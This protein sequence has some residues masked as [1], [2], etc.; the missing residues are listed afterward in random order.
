MITKQEAI[1]LS[2]IK[3]EYIVKYDGTDKGLLFTHPELKN[4]P[5]NCGLCDYARDV[6]ILSDIRD[7]SNINQLNQ[8]CNTVQYRISYVYLA[9][10]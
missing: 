3:W 8:K 5:S 1:R 4:L 9:A 10:R 7:E 2:L 6:A